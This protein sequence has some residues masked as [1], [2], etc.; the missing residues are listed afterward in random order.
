MPKVFCTCGKEV[1][2]KNVGGQYQDTFIGKCL[3]GKNWVLEQPE[4]N[5]FEDEVEQRRRHANKTNCNRCIET[6][7]TVT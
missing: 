5:F 2:L 4:E 1:E 6:S 7:T 3:C